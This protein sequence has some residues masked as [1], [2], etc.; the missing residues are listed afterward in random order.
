MD[1]LGHV[2]N[3]TYLDYVTE[4]REALFAGHPASG[5]SVARHQVEFVRPLVFHRESV[6]VDT[7]VTGVSEDALTLTHEVY[8]AN[9]VGERTVYVRSTTVLD[10]RLDEAER[11]DRK[12]VV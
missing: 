7:W 6:L 8:D 10:H 2:N 5:A 11:V 1:L 12:S 4:A 9:A 3:V